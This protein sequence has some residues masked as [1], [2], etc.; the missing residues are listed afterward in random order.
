MFFHQVCKITLF[1][2]YD[3][4][5][6]KTRRDKAAR[7]SLSKNRAALLL[8]QLRLRF[9]VAYHAQVAL[10]TTKICVWRMKA[11]AEKHPTRDKWHVMQTMDAWYAF[12]AHMTVYLEEDSDMRDRI[13]ALIDA[14]RDPFAVDIRYHRSCW[15]KYVLTGRQDD[16]EKLHVQDVCQSEIKQLFFQHVRSVVFQQHEL[17]TSQSLL[18]DYNTL[19]RKFDFELV[20]TKSTY[21]K[22]HTTRAVTPVHGHEDYFCSR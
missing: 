22:L 21:I 14:V 1:S 3:V 6:A 8:H 12:K 10:F 15:R 5:L 4:Q 9:H 16:A 18:A 17:T 11:T 13:L 20:G 7:R 19:L 2:K